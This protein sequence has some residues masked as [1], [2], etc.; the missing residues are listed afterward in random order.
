MFDRLVESYAKKKECLKQAILG[1]PN[2]ISL[3]MFENLHLQKHGRTLDYKRH[4][5]M[6][7]NMC[8]SLDASREASKSGHTKRL[9]H[10]T[11]TSECEANIELQLFH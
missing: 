4:H 10:L 11:E 5:E 9:S 3:E 1:C 2:L 7:F 6:V 8:G